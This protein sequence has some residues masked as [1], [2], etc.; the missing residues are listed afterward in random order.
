MRA[1]N[2]ARLSKTLHSPHLLSTTTRKSLQHPG[3]SRP[4]RQIVTPARNPGSSTSTKRSPSV[5]LRPF[6]QYWTPASNASPP[7]KVKGMRPW[8]PAGVGSFL[9]LRR[10]RQP[11]ARDDLVDPLPRQPVVACNLRLRITRTPPLVDDRVAALEH[12]G[13]PSVRFR[14]LQFQLRVPLHDGYTTRRIFRVNRK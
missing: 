13:P 3:A 5:P 7:G 9:S 14:Q 1:R 11:D 6:A 8:T 2:S 4:H 12:D 10:D